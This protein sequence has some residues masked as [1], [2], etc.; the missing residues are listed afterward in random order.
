MMDSNRSLDSEIPEGLKYLQMVQNL[1]EECCKVPDERVSD[2]EPVTKL[3]G[4]FG[5]LLS[6]LDR[7]ASCYWE[8][9]KGDHIIES[10]LGRC[11]SSSFS[12]LI[13]I[14]H[15]Y[16]DEA[17]ALARSV[18]EI[19]N[20]LILF[21]SDQSALEKWKVSDKRTRINEFG[22][23]KVRIKLE[24]LDV[25]TPIGEELYSYLSERAAHVTPYTRPQVHNEA[26]KA[27][28]GGVY[29]EPGARICLNHIALA[30]GVAAN[31]VV[32]LIP[33]EQERREY[34]EHATHKLLASIFEKEPED[35]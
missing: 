12:S 1:S 33:I 13:L 11:C 19:A 23:V 21:A 22:P 14:R 3:L 6:L 28:V 34:I 5:T 17:L 7:L 20:L 16:Y 31:A 30:L 15:G 26:L 29:Q 8:C 2:L 27:M 32:A 10:L 35:F 24:K 9:Q 18:D 25:P 4:N